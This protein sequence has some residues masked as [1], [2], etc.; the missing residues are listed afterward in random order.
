M[1]DFLPRA[2]IAGCMLL[3]A[4]AMAQSSA[5]FEAF[6]GKP[7]LDKVADL[8]MEYVLRDPRIKDQFKSSNIPRLKSLLADQFCV[9]LGG[10]LRL[11]GV[12]CDRRTP[13]WG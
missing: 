7:G 10:P 11:P 12:T 13:A 3:S 9:L 8:G 5:A 2:F 1:R 6:G 4:P